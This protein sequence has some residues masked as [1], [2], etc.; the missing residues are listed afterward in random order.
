MYFTWVH[1]MQCSVRSPIR[2]LIVL[3]Q[4]L[5]RRLVRF[6]FGCTKFGH[7][8]HA[9]L[10]V[11][12]TTPSVVNLSILTLLIMWPPV[13]KGMST[14]SNSSESWM[15]VTRKLS[16]KLLCPD[17][18]IQQTL[19]RSASS[20]IFAALVEYRNSLYFDGRLAV[21]GYCDVVAL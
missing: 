11:S 20:N 12:E 3:R 15:L 2:L 18:Y 14:V 16:R 5:G 17:T 19:N 21:R 4:K 6:R 7:I 8:L 13:H 9:A 10:H 1:I